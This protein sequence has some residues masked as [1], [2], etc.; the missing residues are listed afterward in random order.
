LWAPLSVEELISR[1]EGQ[2]V[3]LKAAVRWNTYKRDT[4]VWIRFHPYAAELRIP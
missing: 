2:K 3:E 1:S 4:D